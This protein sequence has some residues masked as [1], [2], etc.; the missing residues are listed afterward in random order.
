MSDLSSIEK[1]KLENMF[2]MKNGYVLNL[3]EKNLFSDNTFKAFILD[4]TGINIYEEKYGNEGKSKAKRLRAFWKQESNY[5]VGKLIL[6]L[7]EF[8]KAEKSNNGL[9]VSLSEQS[10]FDECFQISQRLMQEG[11]N[12]NVDEIAVINAHFNEE[13]TKAI[14][15]QIELAKFIIWV[16]VAWFTD[17]ELFEKLLAKKNEG[18]NVQLIIIDDDINKNSGLR[19]EELETYKIP[20]IGKYDN[21]NNAQ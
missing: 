8:W 12:K 6:D 4:S 14:I 10:L 11:K 1:N 15:E 18:V 13:I 19:Y 5:I 7:L 2:N 9:M 16:A 20:K 21:I 17:R 3:P